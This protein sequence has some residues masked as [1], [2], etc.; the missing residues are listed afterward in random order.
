M[1]SYL[2]TLVEKITFP[3]YEHLTIRW[4]NGKKVTLPLKITKY[5]TH[6][7]PK[8]EKQEDG[9]VEFGGQQMPVERLDAVRNSMA[10]RENHIQNLEITMPDVEAPIQ[11]PIV[12]KVK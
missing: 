12:K 5:W 2:K 4:K 11:I 7:Y 8:L 3:D 10:M 9:F 6:P 1:L